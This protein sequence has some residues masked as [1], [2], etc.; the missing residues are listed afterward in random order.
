MQDLVLTAPELRDLGPDFTT[1]AGIA[2][3]AIE[4][5]ATAEQLA[6]MLDTQLRWEA[7]EARKAFIDALQQFNQNPPEV[8]KTKTVEYVNKD[9]SKTKYKHAELDKASVILR[10]ALLKVGITYSWRPSEKDGRV[11]VT[12]VFRHRLGH[13]EDMS[14]LSGPP[15]TSGG[16]NS[17]QAIGSTNYYLE[18][19]TLLAACGLA[20]E[21]DKDGVANVDP[22]WLEEQVAELG[23]CETM[24]GLNVAFQSA[25]KV[26][27]E[28]VKDFAAYAAL[29]EAKNKRKKELSK[30][31]K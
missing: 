2:Q 19:Y 24:E 28:D 6:L 30:G 25:A 8:L 12:C 16:K 4:Q 26:A 15:D 11:V 21:A 23:R 14:T 1:R 22:K 17:V 20:P 31:G 5:K 18:R 3:W 27:I 13:C 9:G 29:K 7:N 10:K